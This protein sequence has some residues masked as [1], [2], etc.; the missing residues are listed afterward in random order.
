MSLSLF[1]RSL[2]QRRDWRGP[3]HKRLVAG[4]KYIARSAHMARRQSAWLGE[5]YGSPRMSALVAHDP[6]LHERWHHHYINR[7]LGH[8]RRLAVIRSHYRYA[9]GN[10][11]RA[12][13]EAVYLHGHFNLGTLVLKDGSELLL[14]LRRPLGRSRE[15]E[16]A[17]CLANVQGQL[18]S[19]ATFS[20]ADDGHTLLIG[21]LQGASAELGR[22][23]VRELTKQSYGLRPKNL[24]FSLLLA[25]GSFT[26]AR[27]VRGVSNLAHPFAGEAD[28]IKA[29]YD[30]FWEE[31]QGVLEADG[32]FA[33]P[34][35]EPV[36]D[37]AQVES[38]HRSAFRRREQ[39][40]RD[41]CAQLLAALR[42]QPQ[43]LPQAA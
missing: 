7:R 6:R 30:G 23:A 8:A 35:I 42:G 34:V 28:K 13:T 2:R 15:G 24:L 25:F 38:K 17:L 29:D 33:L 9:F 5:L 19:S 39:L 32:F 14:E 31:C 26:G 41:A 16:L 40:R 43:A 3:F 11:P 1:L 20:I 27:Q 12:L 36:R 21:C 37:E 18:L 22:E 4:L 10:L